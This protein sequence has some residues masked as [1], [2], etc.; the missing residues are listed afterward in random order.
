MTIIITVFDCTQYLEKRFVVNFVERERVGE[1]LQMHYSVI[2]YHRLKGH[3][4][5][6]LYRY[7]WAKKNVFVI[8]GAFGRSMFSDFF[9]HSTAEL[10]VE[11]INL[12]VFI[13]HH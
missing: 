5:N 6:E 11:T 13:A 3:A 2:G 4:G 7:L 1:L 9:K 10:V 12:P 8:M